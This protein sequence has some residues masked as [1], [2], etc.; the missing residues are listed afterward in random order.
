M[1][2]R[3]HYRDRDYNERDRRERDR[4]PKDRD[5]DRDRRSRDRD[6]ERD[7]R[8]DRD[9]Y[10]RD[11][12]REREETSPEIKRSSEKRGRMVESAGY[13][14][15]RDP[16]AHTLSVKESDAS[17]KIEI[18]KKMERLAR[19]QAW[20]Q[21]QLQVSVAQA[22]QPTKQKTV[23]SG[24]FATA[25]ET[26][27]PSLQLRRAYKSIEQKLSLLDPNDESDYAK[28]KEEE[29]S[30]EGDLEAEVTQ[31][32]VHI[33]IKTEAVKMETE[34]NGETTEEE[35]PMEIDVD[36]LEAYMATIHTIAR[37]DSRKAVQKA[38]KEQNKT[39]KWEEE[40]EEKE[41]VY[42]RSF[43][44]MFNPPSRPKKQQRKLLEA[45]DHKTVDYLPFRKDFYIEV[46]EIA[47]MTPEEVS[48]LRKSLDSI[49][50]RG[51]T[52]PAPIKTFRQC[53]LKEK[54]C[55][56]PVT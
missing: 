37:E 53:G 51:K 1:S 3:G 29:Y 41:I 30:D 11:K 18:E 42:A 54:M 40:E 34:G 52:C 15:I 14:N 24:L 46:P 44:D 38:T 32:G 13:T 49:K 45:V 17:A 55:V 26:S 23:S 10:R 50:I 47:K 16:R 9:R 25:E 4:R 5:R 2:D 33:D 28:F 31:P 6:R 7:D 36:P 39:L 8:G 56:L 21:Q 22:P 27:M 19:V 43:A 48:A 12:K 20:K 35:K